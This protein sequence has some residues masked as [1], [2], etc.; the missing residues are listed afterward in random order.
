MQASY[1]HFFAISAKSGNQGFRLI[2]LFCHII[3][4]PSVNEADSG[5]VC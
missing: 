2:R 1:L 3:S 5:C 4:F